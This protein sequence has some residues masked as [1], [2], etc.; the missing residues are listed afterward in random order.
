MNAYL[1]KP[2]VLDTLVMLLR[3][4]CAVVNGLAQDCSMEGTRFAGQPLPAPVT[5]QSLPCRFLQEYPRAQL[6]IIRL[7][8]GEGISRATTEFT[9]Y[10]G[11]N[12]LQWK[13]NDG[14]GGMSDISPTD[15]DQ[16]GLNY[17]YL[18][19]N[20]EDLSHPG[21]AIF[22]SATNVPICWPCPS[23]SKGEQKAVD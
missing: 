7:D 11:T 14:G 18:F 12:R 6:R 20:N 22:T 15:V 21:C 17:F 8:A 19:P 4:A 10:D 16:E 23:R 3:T 5:S 1:S 2:I 13:L 9:W